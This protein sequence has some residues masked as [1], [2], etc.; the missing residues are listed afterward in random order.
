MAQYAMVVG[1]FKCGFLWSCSLIN[2]RVCRMYVARAKFNFY[3]LISLGW[4]LCACLALASLGRKRF[5]FCIDESSLI[6][7]GRFYG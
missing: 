2:W 5:V 6:S 7:N 1:L 4:L 3:G